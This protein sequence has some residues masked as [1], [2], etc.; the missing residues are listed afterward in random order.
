MGHDNVLKAAHGPRR[1][2]CFTPRRPASGGPPDSDDLYS[3]FGLNQETI[4]EK[5]WT[6]DELKTMAASFRLHNH[7][8]K[9]RY[10][11]TL[12]HA[13]PDE[14]VPVRDI[15]NFNENDYYDPPVLVRAYAEH[16]MY[17]HDPPLAMMR[18]GLRCLPLR[19]PA[20]N[21]SRCTHSGAMIITTTDQYRGKGLPCE[22]VDPQPDSDHYPPNEIIVHL[23]HQY[24]IAAHHVYTFPVVHQQNITS[25]M[26]CAAVSE[27]FPDTIAKIFPRVPDSNGYKMPVVP[28]CYKNYQPIF[29]TLP[30]TAGGSDSIV[31]HGRK[32]P[33]PSAWLHPKCSLE[34]GWHIDMQ[35]SDELIDACTYM[36]TWPINN[37]HG[38]EHCHKIGFQVA[39]HRHRGS[40]SDNAVV[41]FAVNFDNEC[42]NE[43]CTGCWK[44]T[45]VW[46]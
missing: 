4:D 38:A 18:E 27:G 30:V 32:Q 28:T 46:W 12:E 9:P 26:R 25:F 34:H 42:D 2:I 35:D 24:T 45:L 13:K 6:E 3:F 39:E 41:L 14:L 43:E 21:G 22:I 7:S 16:E 1:F 23:G 19:I 31:S 37:A 20:T 40:G 11:V 15:S 36:N 10:G 33:L 17:F 5:E 8:Y 29:A 44:K